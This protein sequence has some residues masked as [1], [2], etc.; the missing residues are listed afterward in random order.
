[1]N[2]RTPSGT[3]LESASVGL[4]DILAYV[5]E[6]KKLLDRRPKRPGDVVGQPEGGIE[7]SLFEKDDRLPPDPDGLRQ[8]RLR[9]TQLR[10]K[11]LNSGLHGTPRPDLSA[12]GSAHATSPFWK[13]YHWKSFTENPNQQDQPD[14]HRLDI[15]YVGLVAAA[16]NIGIAAAF[17][18]SFIFGK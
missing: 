16:L 7:F 4:L 18:I 12:D 10:M 9:Y 17:N 3:D 11:L 14:G 5:L 8:I 2:L 13:R 15:Q 6:R 1:M